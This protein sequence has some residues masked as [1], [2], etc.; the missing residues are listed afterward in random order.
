MFLPVL[1]VRDFGIWAFVAFAIPNVFGAMAMGLVIPNAEASERI[2]RDHRWAMLWFSRATIAYQAF[3]A[4]WMLTQ[5]LGWWTG[6]MYVV[7]VLVM[8]AAVKGDRDFSFSALAAWLVSI[9]VGVALWMHHDLSLPPRMGVAGAWQLAPACMLGFLM[10]PYLDL[11][12]HRALQRAYTSAGR[13]RG[14]ATTRGAFI[15][16][17]V[18]VFGSMIALTLLYAR[19]LIE[20][21]HWATVAVGIHM[22]VQLAVTIVLHQVEASRVLR[23]TGHGAYGT[24]DDPRES[25]GGKSAGLNI[26]KPV[27]LGF[28]LGLGARWVPDMADWQAGEYGYRIFLSLYGL[29]FPVYVLFMVIPTV[30]MSRG[31]MLLTI[32]ATTPTYAVGFLTGN[33]IW[34]VFGTGVVF[35]GFI[36]SLWQAAY[37]PTRRIA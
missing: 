17:F 36:T 28:G 1:L 4:G 9:G 26:W 21:R 10:C 32:L 33:P 3:F 5:M 8:V 37:V 25:A 31:L 15:L 24:R 35:M 29:A 22:M 20:H 7:M 12:F 16:G 19:A 2:V 34:L 30:R 23:E 13:G 11:T 6:L 14:R 18:V 27:L